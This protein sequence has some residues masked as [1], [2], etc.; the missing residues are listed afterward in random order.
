MHICVCVYLHDISMNQPPSNNTILKPAD[1]TYIIALTHSILYMFQ[2]TIVASTST[3]NR[4]DTAIAFRLT[5]YALEFRL[6]SFPTLI[7]QSR[8]QSRTIKSLIKSVK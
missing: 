6:P 2:F 8:M 7:F 5:G 4:P 3:F 1:V